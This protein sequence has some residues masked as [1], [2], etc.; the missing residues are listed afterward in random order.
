VKVE[1][2]YSTENKLQLTQFNGQLSGSCSEMPLRKKKVVQHSF[3]MVLNI[4]FTVKM[5]QTTA[6]GD[7][8]TNTA[9]PGSKQL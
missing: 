7:A 8:G 4:G 1:Q 9:R 3:L 6:V 2:P 5:Q